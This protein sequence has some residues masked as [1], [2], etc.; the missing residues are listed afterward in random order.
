MP[1][2]GE[3]D[4][5]S[6]SLARMLDLGVDRAL[7][8]PDELGLILEH[9]LAA[10]LEF[11]IVGVEPDQLEELRS[12]ETGPAIETFGDLVFH[13]RP[14][15]RLLELTKEFARASRGHPDR[16]LPDE[17]ASALYLASIVVALARCGK[18]ITGL[19]DDGLR[20]GLTWAL[21]QAWLE[22][23]IRELLDEGRRRVGG[24]A[25]GA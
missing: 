24:P 19:S 18:R 2:R 10:P 25:S 17:V 16:P 6:Q 7:W 14:P 15:V 12:V 4:T 9:Q 13:P 22:G 20:Y 3:R 8:E 11:D 5:N 23:A 1:K 21:K